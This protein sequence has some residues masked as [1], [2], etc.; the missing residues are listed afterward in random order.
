MLVSVYQ[1]LHDFLSERDADDRLTLLQDAIVETL[2]AVQQERAGRVFLDKL[3]Q[4]VA[5][6]RVVE[7]R[8]PDLCRR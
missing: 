3:T 4:L 1:L 5:S 2:K 8:F 6:G 7:S